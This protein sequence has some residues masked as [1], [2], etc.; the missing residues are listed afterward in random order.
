MEVNNQ[1]ITTRVNFSNYQPIQGPL[2]VVTGRRSHLREFIN[3]PNYQSELFKP[4]TYLSHAVSSRPLILQ[5]LPVPPNQIRGTGPAPSPKVSPHCFSLQNTVCWLRTEG[6]V[7]NLKVW[8]NSPPNF[9]WALKRVSFQNHIGLIPGLRKQD[10]KTNLR[11]VSC[12]IT[13]LESELNF[14]VLWVTTQSD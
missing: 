8:L 2:T 11:S 1:P 4:S 7:N 14:S 9:S 5:L 6:N 3:Q 12:G 10:H 13:E